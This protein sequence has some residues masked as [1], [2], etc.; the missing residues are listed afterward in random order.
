MEFHFRCMDCARFGK[1]C[2]D[3]TGT[4]PAGSCFVKPKCSVCEYY[5]GVNQ[6]SGICTYHYRTK[7][8]TPCVASGHDDFVS[9]SDSCK[10]FRDRHEKC[11]HCKHYQ[12][13]RSYGIGYCDIMPPAGQVQKRKH[14]SASDIC[15]DFETDMKFY[16][17]FTFEKEGESK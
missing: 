15:G 16:D 12:K 14:V 2:T 5:A 1:S 3:M 17:P 4:E 13:G 9:A 8:E 6:E 10:Y 11:I 7:K